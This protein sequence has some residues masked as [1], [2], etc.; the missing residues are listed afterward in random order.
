[1]N[2]R[3]ILIL[4]KLM[5]LSHPLNSNQIASSFHISLRTA[6]MDLREVLF[7]IAIPRNFVWLKR[8]A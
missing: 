3:Q 2:H 6:Q 8:I 5:T 7:I 4:K 1:M